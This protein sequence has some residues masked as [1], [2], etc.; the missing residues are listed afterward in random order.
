MEKKEKKVYIEILRMAATFAVVFLHINMTL[1]ENYTSDELGFFN[2]A[3]FND[4]Y[5]CVK[6]AVPC[7]IMISGVLLL[8]PARRMDWKKIRKYVVRMLLVLATFGVGYALMEL[9]FT[10]KSF[11]VPMLFQAVLNTLQGA[12]WSHMWYIYMLIGLY[13]ITIPLR[14]VTEKMSGKALEILVVILILG[15]FFIPSINTLTGLK[16][17]NFMQIGEYVTWYLTGYYL[18][19]T[20]R[21]LFVPACIGTVVSL[22]FM[23]VSETVLVCQTG[24]A[25]ALN[26]QTS[27]VFTLVLGASVFIL[28]KHIF[29]R[30]QAIHPV[31]RLIC[32]TSFGI[33][34]IHP[35]FINFIYKVLHITPLS[36]PIAAGIAV[37]FTVVFTLSLSTAFV[38]KKIPLVKNLL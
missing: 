36:F 37:L 22:V 13:L 27:N 38:L 10:Q 30:K 21:K 19:V 14:A 31:V 11:S 2:F 8:D 15:N 17:V 20:T 28:F 23:I 18:S 4:G 9:V 7:F 29:E 6:W 35:L 33:Y 24:E 3:V 34:L 26:H 16:L 1:V 5:I 32:R 25:F 12:S